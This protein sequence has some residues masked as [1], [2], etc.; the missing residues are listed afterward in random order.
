MSIGTAEKK[1][2]AT[3]SEGAAAVE[4]DP[5]KEQPT[6]EEK[7]VGDKPAEPGNTGVSEEGAV[8]KSRVALTIAD[9]I[10]ADH[11]QASQVGHLC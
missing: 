10:A 5:A 3:A 4:E 11:R 7:P 1:N 6:A 9:K 8:H 2:E